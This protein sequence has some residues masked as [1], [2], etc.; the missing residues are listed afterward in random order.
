M[1][2]YLEGP[3]TYN[4]VLNTKLTQTMQPDG[5]ENS[6]ISDYFDMDFATL[7]HKLLQPDEFD[8]QVGQLRSR[9]VEKQDSYFKPIYHKRIPADG[10]APY[11]SSIW[12]SLY[13]LSSLNMLT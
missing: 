12:V 2:R 13:G 6:Q 11:L 7:P 1:G 9:F 5:L 10:F 8:R 4:C 3:L